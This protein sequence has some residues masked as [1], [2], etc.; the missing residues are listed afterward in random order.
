MAEK[1]P[2]V[3][4]PAEIW[5]GFEFTSIHCAVLVAHFKDVAAV[6]SELPPSEFNAL[7]DSFQTSVLEL[8]EEF[9][10]DGFPIGEVQ[11]SG[12]RLRICFFDKAEVGWNY[13]LDGPDPISG[14]VRQA[15]IHNCQDIKE[16]LAF[17]ALL[18]AIRLKTRWLTQE[19]NLARIRAHLEH[20][21]LS[22]GIHSG[23]V[24][25][26]ERAN[27]VI[28]VE[29][30]MLE[31]A[32][33]V[34]SLVP[35]PQFSHIMVSQ[36]ARDYIVRMVRGHSQMRKRIYF[37]EHKPDEAALKGFTGANSVSELKFFHRIGIHLTAEEVKPFEA[38]FALNRANRWAYNMLADYHGYT[39]KQWMRMFALSKRALMVHPGDEKILLDMA[40]TYLE[41]NKP[42]LA[43]KCVEESLVTNPNFDLAHEM[44][45][46]IACFLNDIE[47][48]IEHWRNAMY[49]SP[50]SAL[51]S[52][53]LG[54][55]LLEDNR[56]DEGYFFIEDA[57]RKYPDYVNNQLFRETL[58]DLRKAGKL[59]H[60]LELYME[61]L[62]EEGGE[63]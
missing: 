62:E 49:L 27:G 46:R 50:D 42:H 24:F 38:M 44:L 60:N 10:Q 47:G 1:P 21:D 34:I 53:N 28:C 55:A 41:I 51:N 22:I 4:L 2:V 3:D 56:K 52:F 7:V 8:V 43:K 5:Q 37:C 23:R 9:K 54:L 13:Q 12:T 63:K 14:S 25:L 40:N 29:G 36:L 15:T 16:T 48:Q 57:L 58:A 59:P 6:V 20:W 32:D 31:L 30:G 45:A 26:K 33:K 19:F 18:A 17:K 11:L 39:K 61:L 35:K